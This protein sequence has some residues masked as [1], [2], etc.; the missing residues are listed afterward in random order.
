MRNGYDWMVIGISVCETVLKNWM[1]K[2][3]LAVH[4]VYCDTPCAL[5]GVM[6]FIARFYPT[7]RPR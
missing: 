2:C 6:S 3:C 7:R 1:F 4:L 5:C